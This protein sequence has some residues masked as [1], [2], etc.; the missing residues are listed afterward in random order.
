MYRI[1][2]KRFDLPIA[3]NACLHRRMQREGKVRFYAEHGTGV[4][5]VLARFRAQCVRPEIA[6]GAPPPVG[7][8]SQHFGQYLFFTD[9]CCVDM[10]RFQ[11][12]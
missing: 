10:E 11:G 8:L 1:Y 9:E 6:R 12:Y 7:L 4:Y 5:Y 3:Q 2:L